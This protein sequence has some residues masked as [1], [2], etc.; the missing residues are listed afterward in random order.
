MRPG[1]CSANKWR[2]GKADQNIFMF[3]VSPDCVW[4][5]HLHF[6]VLGPLMPHPEERDCYYQNVKS[7]SSSDSPEII[8]IIII[9]IPVPNRIVKFIR[10]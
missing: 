7:H 8:T 4:L 5:Y 3:N 10:H 2:S 9:L 6:H 1:P